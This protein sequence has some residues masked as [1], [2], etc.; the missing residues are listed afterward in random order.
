MSLRKVC[1]LWAKLNEAPPIIFHKR[2]SLV[3]HDGILLCLRKI[4]STE[5]FVDGKR[6]KIETAVWTWIKHRNYKQ[7]RDIS[8]FRMEWN[9][10]HNEEQK[11]NSEPTCKCVGDR[12]TGNRWDNNCNSQN[13]FAVLWRRR[14]IRRDWDPIEYEDAIQTFGLPRWLGPFWNT[15]TDRTENNLENFQSRTRANNI[16]QRRA[17][18]WPLH[19]RRRLFYRWPECLAE[20][21]HQN[22]FQKIRYSFLEMEII[23][24][25]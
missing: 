1:G 11:T 10:W 25:K 12:D 6:W 24:P 16:L 4:P 7:F 13:W 22:L 21:Y 18:H 23:V 5:F 15:T 8:N 19:L 9:H 14:T 20:K 17:C 2:F 3:I